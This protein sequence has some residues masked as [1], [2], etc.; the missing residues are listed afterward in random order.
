MQFKITIP[1][2]ITITFLLTSILKAQQ[3]GTEI[4]DIAPEIELKNPD[5]KEITLSSL[6]GKIVVVDF[7]AS[8]CIPCIKTNAIL[9]KA[10]KK[11]KDKKFTN[12]QGFTIL[13]VS[14][15]RSK[16][17]WVNAI[18]HDKLIWQNHVSSL[19]FWDCPVAGKYRI[20]TIPFSVV[21]D[22]NGVIIARLNSLKDLDRLLS[23]Y[24]KVN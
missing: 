4:G 17:N 14:L 19:K 10:Y 7:W 16:T 24:L 3:I 2:L 20:E 11:Y 8:W 22:G 15:D 18:K 9:V 21:I 12:G 1:V 13:S 5:G 6:K 23:S